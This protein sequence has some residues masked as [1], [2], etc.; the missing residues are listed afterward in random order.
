MPL[1]AL[2]PVPKTSLSLQNAPPQIYRDY[3]IASIIKNKLQ[4]SKEASEVR[5]VMNYPGYA[6]CSAAR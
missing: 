1:R 5:L 3:E 4:L 6:K 2:L